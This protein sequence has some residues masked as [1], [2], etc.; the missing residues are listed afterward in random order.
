MT[1]VIKDKWA[2]SPTSPWKW[3]EQIQQYKRETDGYTLYL[4]QRAGMHWWFAVPGL[5]A[6][7]HIVEHSFEGVAKK[8]EAIAVKEGLSFLEHVQKRTINIRAMV[9]TLQEQ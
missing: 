8:V 3:D 5:L 4:S 6:Q 1:T 7:M 9:N 2:P